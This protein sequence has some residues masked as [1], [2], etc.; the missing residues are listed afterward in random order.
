MFQSYVWNKIA[1]ERIKRWGMRP[2]VGDL[3]LDKETQ[4]DADD[5]VAEDSVKVVTDVTSVN[6]SEI[7]LP[8]RF[9]FNIIKSV[10]NGGEVSSVSLDSMIQIASRI[11]HNIST[12]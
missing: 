5:G 2:V 8:V 12:E 11:Q 10:L 7:V 3:Y 4:S 1:T 9:L 6:I